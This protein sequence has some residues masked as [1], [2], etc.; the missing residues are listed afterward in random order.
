MR[1]LVVGATGNVGRHVV[2]HLVVA[3]VDVRAVSRRPADAGLPVEVVAGDLDHP[4]SLTAALADVDRMYLL[5]AGNTRHVV[6]LAKRAGVRRVVLL[7]SLS[8]GMEGFP[9]GDHHR[10]AELAVEDSGLEWT[11]VRPGMFLTN[12]LSWSGRIRD[13]GVVREP[14]ARARQ[15]P[16]HEEDI[17]AVAATALLFDHHVGKALPLSGPESLAKPD[18]VA[19]I[20][21]A[22][23]RPLRFEQVSPDQWDDIPPRYIADIMLSI[24]ARAERTPD[25]VLTTVQD[26][27]GRPART[28]ADWAVDHVADFR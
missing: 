20:G 23:G 3:G 14:H 11:H 27:L 9:G 28:A 5:A 7:S 12:L 1:I 4:E 24:W 10:A 2:D 18:L 21:K 22:L 15:A 13:T 17:A 19:A 26:V 25:L 6:D 16:V 8:A